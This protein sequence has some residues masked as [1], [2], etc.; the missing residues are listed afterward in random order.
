MLVVGEKIN[1]LNPVIYNAVKRNDITPVI[2]MAERQVRA[3]A[4]A[5]DINMGPGRQAG[6]KLPWLMSHLAARF[7]E[8]D[9]FLSADLPYII[10]TL[11]DSIPGPGVVI[12]AATA[13]MDSLKRYISTAESLGCKLVVFLI[14][15][16]LM[17]SG[18]ETTCLVAEEVLEEAERLGF[19]LE[20]LYLDPLLRS[21]CNPHTPSLHC[22][23]DSALIINSLLLI[24]NLREEEIKTIVGLGNIAQ[25]YGKEE[26]SRYHCSLLSLLKRPCCLLL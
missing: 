16:G 7:P 15:K 13:D 19:P 8:T 26:R 10:D 1:I 3:G 24:R 4:D 12:N 5:L 22:T 20:R 21:V 23:T 9:F 11:K 14:R 18:P 25:G 6:E 17:P 2:E